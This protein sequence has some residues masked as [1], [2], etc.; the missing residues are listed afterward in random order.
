MIDD[1]D[2]A[3][4][5]ALMALPDPAAH[6]DEE[7]WVRLASA[8]MPEGEREAVL[9]HVV[10][11]EECTRIYRGLRMLAAEARPFD[12]SV[13]AFEPVPQ[14]VTRWRWRAAGALGAVAA[15]VVFLLLRPPT[16]PN[17]VAPAQLGTSDLRSAGVSAPVPLRPLGQVA[18][19][20]GSF[21]W[22]PLPDAR[23]Y[24]VRLLDAQGEVVW[25]SPEVVE[26][27]AELPPAVPLRRGR[28]YWQVLA[29]PASGGEPIASTVADFELR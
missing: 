2:E 13:P 24:R 14:P 8:E 10:R 7:T 15:A 21:H 17:A 22:R 3:L 23:A 28:H 25:T 19:R 26:P 16:S 9:D 1:H 11:C 18:E 27:S 12:S 20:P 29:H 6:V 5:A 4:R